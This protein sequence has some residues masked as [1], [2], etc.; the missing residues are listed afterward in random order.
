MENQKSDENQGY[1][2]GANDLKKEGS[3]V[4]LDGSAGKFYNFVFT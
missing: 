2:M 3:F 1:W 4:W